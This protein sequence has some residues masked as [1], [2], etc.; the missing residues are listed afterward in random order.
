[1]V[2]R[3]HCSCFAQDAS[4]F[5]VASFTV[6]CRFVVVISSSNGEVQW[7]PMVVRRREGG[8][9]TVAAGVGM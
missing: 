3:E 2:E 7:L 1:M 8:D 5:T 6:E 9:G 4:P